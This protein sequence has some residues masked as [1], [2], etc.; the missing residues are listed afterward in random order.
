MAKLKKE[1]SIFVSHMMLHTGDKPYQCIKCDYAYKELTQ[2]SNM[3]IHT[4]DKPY[5]CCHSIDHSHRSHTNGA[6]VIKF[7]GKLLD[8]NLTR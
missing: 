8:N 5:K 7:C 3:I 6:N 4:V 1:N 2:A